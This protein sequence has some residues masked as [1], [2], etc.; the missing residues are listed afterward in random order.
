[1]SEGWFTDLTKNAWEESIMREFLNNYAYVTFLVSLLD[2][3]KQNDCFLSS[4]RFLE[5]TFDVKY[6]K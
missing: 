5:G 6:E 3:T 4:S 1:M 2:V